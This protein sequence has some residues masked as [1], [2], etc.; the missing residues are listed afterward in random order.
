MT[1]GT[2][3]LVWILL[4]NAGEPSPNADNILLELRPATPFLHGQTLKI[5]F[6]PRPLIVIPLTGN[7]LELLTAPKK[8]GVTPPFNIKLLLCPPGMPGTLLF[9]SYSIEPAVDPWSEFALIM[10]LIQVSGRFPLPSVLT[11]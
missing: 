7:V 11:D 2:W 1:N 8:T 10:L 3:L 6:T 9:T 5:L 4:S